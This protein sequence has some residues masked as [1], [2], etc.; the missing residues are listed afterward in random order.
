M[1]TRIGWPAPANQS[2][3]TPAARAEKPDRYAQ[4][5]SLRGLAA[6]TVVAEH[7]IRIDPGVFRTIS[8][9]LDWAVNATPLRI[10]WA[11][12]N[13]V[14]L[15][16]VLSGF[17][18]ALQVTRGLPYLSFAVHRVFRLQ[19]PY[20]VSISG[21]MFLAW[22]AVGRGPRLSPWFNAV[23]AHGPTWQDALTQWSLVGHFDPMAF[24]P[25]VWSLVQ[26]MRISLLFP[27][28]VLFC[29]KVG[30]RSVIA[31]PFLFALGSG[32]EHLLLR[33]PLAADLSATLLY[34]PLFVVGILVA[35]DRQR[36]VFLTRRLRPALTVVVAVLAVIL[37]TYPFWFQPRARL[38]HLWVID[39]T[40]VAAGATGFIVLVL[41]TPRLARW[42]VIPPFRWLGRISYSLYLTHVLVLLAIVHAFGGHVALPLL[43][44]AG[45]VASLLVGDLF[46]RVVERPAL[47]L[48]RRLSRSLIRRRPSGDA[49]RAA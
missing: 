16:F 32:L 33:W 17:V 11:G 14:L 15:F 9:T 20:I 48:G 42:L 28:L 5:D 4:L 7:C 37:Y 2:A 25:P 26:E 22:W 45:L 36:L 12:G 18:L 39:T 29:M 41:S 19:V 38:P 23:W 46:H 10:F 24:N 34:V 47:L 40:L 6:L 35:N 49:Q 8:P 27:L 31:I 44:G 3:T 30:R 1:R 21:A 43:L 13:A